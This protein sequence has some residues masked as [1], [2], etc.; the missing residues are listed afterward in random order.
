MKILWIVE[1]KQFLW[2]ALDVWK[3]LKQKQCWNLGGTLWASVVSLTVHCIFVVWGTFSLSCFSF[4]SGLNASSFIV[5]WLFFLLLVMLQSIGCPSSPSHL[6]SVNRKNDYNSVSG[7]SEVAALGL[8]Q[9][10]YPLV[11]NI[12]VCRSPWTVFE[13]SWECKCMCCMITELLTIQP[14][15]QIHELQS[16]TK[17]TDRGVKY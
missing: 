10:L 1:K 12:Y 17:C 7:G 13:H 6:Y 9:S 2:L 11:C 8:S 4:L 14:K 3:L 5:Y 15:T 16:H